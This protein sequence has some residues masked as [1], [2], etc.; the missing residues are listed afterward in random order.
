M[1]P[2]EVDQSCVQPDGVVTVAEPSLAINAISRSPAVS[3]LGIVTLCAVMSVPNSTGVGVGATT[4]GVTGVS[5]NTRASS[6][7]WNGTCSPDW[8]VRVS[9]SP[10]PFPVVGQRVLDG[11]VRPQVAS[12]L[13]EMMPP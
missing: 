7:C 2:A 12:M 1:E 3:G 11:R 13:A 6:G 4:W 10:A 9:F 8:G 5:G